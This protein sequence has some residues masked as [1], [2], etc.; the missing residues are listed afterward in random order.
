MGVKLCVVCH[1]KKGDCKCGRPTVM[2][3]SVLAKL[4]MA[5]S[6]GCPDTEACT[7]AKISVNSLYDYQKK[8]PEFLA[9]KLALKEE[10]TLKARQTLIKGIGENV[11]TATYWLEK[12]KKDEFGEENTGGATLM[13]R[14][15]EGFLTDGK[16]QVK[17]KTLKI[18]TS[19]NKQ[20]SNES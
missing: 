2:N 7:L 1:T 10:I 12:K 15:F 8:H 13:E 4:E 9:L 6:F 11:S 14:Y 16:L 5:F 19:N 20:I 18:S 17:E 3:E